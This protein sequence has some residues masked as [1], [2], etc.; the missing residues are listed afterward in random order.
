MTYLQLLWAGLLGWIVFGH[1]P[2]GLSVVGMCVV[3]ASGLAMALKSNA[4]PATVPPALA[5]ARAST[6]A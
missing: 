6:P 4:P 5:E 2:D 1:V 3:A